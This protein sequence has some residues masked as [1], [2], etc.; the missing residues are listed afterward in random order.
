V[1]LTKAQSV[2]NKETKRLQALQQLFIELLTAQLPDMV[3]NGSSYRLPNNVH[4][5]LPDQDNERLMMAL[6]EKGIMCAAGSACSASK[7]TA[8]HVLQALGKT[9]AEARASLRIT[10]GRQTTEAAVR[11]FAKVLP[12]LLT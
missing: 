4:I 9:E 3:V 8:S 12:S 1:A 7:E 11:R 10:F 2:R 6:D 5:T